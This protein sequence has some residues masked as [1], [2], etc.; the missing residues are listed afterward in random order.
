LRAGRL[1]TDREKIDYVRDE[2]DSRFSTALTKIQN[3]LTD[4]DS[5][6]GGLNIFPVE[7][8]LTTDLSKYIISLLDK[9]EKANLIRTLKANNRSGTIRKMDKSTSDMKRRGNYQQSNW[10]NELKWEVI[11]GA[12]CNACLKGNHNIYKTGCPT[13]AQFAVCKAFYEK[14]PTDKLQQVLKSY[15]T[16]QSELAHKLRQRRNQDRKTIRLLQDDYDDED[17]MKIKTV[18]FKQY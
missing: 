12:K 3:T 17:I 5:P 4:L 13:F 10:A 7:L 6:N 2:L 11:P 8:K 16:Y 14:C 18:F 9:N 1:Y 15:K